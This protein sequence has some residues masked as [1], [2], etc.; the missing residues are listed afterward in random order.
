[1]LCGTENKAITIVVTVISK[2]SLIKVI[3]P[4]LILDYD[5]QNG[6]RQNNISFIVVMLISFQRKPTIWWEKLIRCLYRALINGYTMCK[7]VTY[8][9]LP[10]TTCL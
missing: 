9:R 1:M 10:E 6:D 7:E 8:K 5:K 2:A 4:D 3:K